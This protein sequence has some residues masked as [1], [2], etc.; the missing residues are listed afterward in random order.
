MCLDYLSEDSEVCEQFIS[1]FP[2]LFTYI[3]RKKIIVEIIR[4]GVEHKVI[5][6]CNAAL[7]YLHA[8]VYLGYSELL[9]KG[10]H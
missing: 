1:S 7:K 5:C 8:S 4:N 6:Y 3:H 10:V 2:L 9:R